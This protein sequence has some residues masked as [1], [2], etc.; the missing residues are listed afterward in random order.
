MHPRRVNLP[1]LEAVVQHCRVGAQHY[2]EVD[3][4]L[5]E[6]VANVPVD[7]V[8]ALLNP[9]LNLV[10]ELV[11]VNDPGFQHIVVAIVRFGVLDDGVDR[12]VVQAGGF[13][14]LFAVGRFACAR[15][16]RRLEESRCRAAHTYSGSAGDDD[17][18]ACANHFC[19]WIFRAVG[20]SCFAPL[21]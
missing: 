19:C 8:P 21:R 12:D 1:V 17:V 2:N 9:R 11:L 5:R 14:E 7:D 20:I 3:P 4:A 6:N 10:E 18:G 13:G 15:S 16:A